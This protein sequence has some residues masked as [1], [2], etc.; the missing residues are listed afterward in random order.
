MTLPAQSHS[1][2]TSSPDGRITMAVEGG[3]AP[4]YSVRLGDRTVL[5]DSRLGLTMKDEAAWGAVKISAGVQS[6]VDR[7]WRP[8]WGK[9]A[10]IRNHYNETRYTLRETAG[11]HR[12]L[13]LVVR[14]Y[15]DGVAFRYLV[16]ARAG[17][18]SF[19]VTHEDTTFNFGD[20]ADVWAG[21]TKSY[22]HAYEQP[23]PHTHLSELKL[24]A[25]VV[26]PL[27]AHTQGIYAAITEADLTD[28]AGMYLN[29]T[30]KGF[31]VDLSPRLDGD[32]LVRAVAPHASP[33]RVIMLSERPGEF[34]E[35][36]I[37]ENLN[38][39]SKIKDTSWI[40]P[41][42]TAWDHWW[43]GDVK[44]DNDTIKRFITFASYMG[45]PYQLIDWQWYGKFNSPDADITKPA[46]Q[47][48]MPMLL[49][50]AK[51]HHVREWLWIHSGDVTRFKNAGKLDAAFATYEKWGIAGVKIDFMDSNDQDMVN[52]YTD[53]V[54]LAAKHH[55]MVDYHGA[56]VPTGL[57]VTWP[58]LLTREGVMGNEWYQFSTLSSPTH[59]LTLPFTRMIAGPMDYTPGGFLN[60]SPKEWK[61][62]LPTE[63]IGS[64]AQELALFVVYYSPFTCVTDDP[65]HYYNQPGLDFLKV[66]PTIWDETR[67]LEGTVGEDIVVARRNGRNWYVGGMTADHPLDYTLTFNFL[68]DGKYTAHIYADPTDP[69]ANY[70]ALSVST[71]TVTKTSVIKLPMRVAGGFAID[72]EPLQR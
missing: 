31:S 1:F 6:R 57:R 3:D 52:W 16:P 50:F 65:E 70:E 25:H 43:S 60:R 28:W 56:Y 45:F 22:H 61:K 54:E 12:V 35:S 36:N 21:E 10:T 30:G 24:G 39:P 37:I 8:V 14:A 58:N 15:N 46:P 40:K 38:P 72:L 23:F 20:D 18:K 48:D 59:R 33:W 26:L 51:D 42:K 32:G 7:T 55:L 5:A 13:T 19:V 47:L 63:V 17:A 66:V 41:G 67:V 44:M 62:T 68:G 53:V 11:A 2:K 34:I 49:Q 29:P 64:R 27:L 71:Q 69:K 9:S 4:H